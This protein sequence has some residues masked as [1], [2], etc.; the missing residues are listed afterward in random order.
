MQNLR[1]ELSFT[2]TCKDKKILCSTLNKQKKGTNISR[3]VGTQ[4]ECTWLLTELP[5]ESNCFPALMDS[6]RRAKK[7]DGEKR[8]FE[9]GDLKARV[10]GAAVNGVLL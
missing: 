4:N 2:T 9:S 3:R 1:R 6:K 8:K 7:R 10:N 5:K